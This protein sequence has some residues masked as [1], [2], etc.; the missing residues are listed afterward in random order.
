[1]EKRNLRHGCFIRIDIS[2]IISMGVVFRRL[3]GIES[4]ISVR[5]CLKPSKAH[6]DEECCAKM[7][8]INF[9]K[10]TNLFE[11]LVDNVH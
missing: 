8:L 11:F 4:R 5:L 2:E 7:C 9:T 6:V 10:Q 1:M 3:I